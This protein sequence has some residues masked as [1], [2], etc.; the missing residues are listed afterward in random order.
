MENKFP[1]NE[2]LEN[3][4]IVKEFT[5]FEAAYFWYGLV[6][7]YDEAIQP[8]FHVS[9]IFKALASTL[10]DVKKGM[11]FFD[12]QYFYKDDF[13]ETPLLGR[14]ELRRWAKECG[15]GKR[16]PEFL[17]TKNERKE[18]R[19]K[20]VFA[21]KKAKD[22]KIFSKKIATIGV[23]SKRKTPAANSPAGKLKH[24]KE[25]VLQNA[26]DYLKG[27]KNNN[28][29]T[30]ED[31]RKYHGLRN[32]SAYFV[33]DYS[34]NNGIK[35]LSECLNLEIKEGKFTKILQDAMKKARDVLG[36]EKHKGG[37]PIKSKNRF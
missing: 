36:I 37:R 8:P 3:L 18:K 5:I 35:F 2:S 7:D 31:F 34:K 9:V 15:P 33:K 27:E 28:R 17:M 22:E 14:G 23:E 16:I 19:L 6:P 13:K 32:T 24:F 4:D 1:K 10:R 30:V 29:L 26:K 20:E 25:A 11:D 12:Y 21:R